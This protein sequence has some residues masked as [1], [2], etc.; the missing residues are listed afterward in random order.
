MSADDVETLKVLAEHLD[1]YNVKFGKKVKLKFSRGRDRDSGYSN[2]R[3][4]T[5]RSKLA[6][7]EVSRR[8]CTSSDGLFRRAPGW[9]GS[10]R[11]RDGG[12]SSHR[13]KYFLTASD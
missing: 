8:F 1:R 3:S 6:P 5:E 2:R 9:R 13:L 7:T 11:D 12:C 10:G 4:G